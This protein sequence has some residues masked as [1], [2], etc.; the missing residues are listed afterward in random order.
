MC[1]GAGVTPGLLIME[2]PFLGEVTKEAA[3]VVPLHC[4]Q[5]VCEQPF[6]VS[7]NPV[8]SFATRSGRRSTKSPL[9]A[10]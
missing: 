3:V 7:M 1:P 8:I 6:S 9:K 4:R 2:A 5:V 10:C